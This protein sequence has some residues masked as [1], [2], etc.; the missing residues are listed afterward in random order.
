[1]AASS[2][3]T[4]TCWMRHCVL[5]EV[6]FLLRCLLFACGASASNLR[7]ALAHLCG[8]PHPMRLWQVDSQSCQLVCHRAPWLGCSPNLL[9]PSKLQVG[10]L[11]TKLLNPI[12]SS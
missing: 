6:A 3:R 5:M 11:A 2:H 4:K 8:Q 9:M 1:M 12:L 10:Q 7:Q